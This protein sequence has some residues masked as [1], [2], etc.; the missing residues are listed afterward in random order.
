MLVAQSLVH[1]PKVIILDEPTAGVGWSCASRCGRL[2][3]VCTAKTNHHSTTHYLEEAERLCER[4][5][6]LVRANRRAGSH[7]DAVAAVGGVRLH[8]KLR[9]GIR[10]NAL[11]EAIAAFGAVVR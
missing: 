6:I 1:R 3:R 8:I 2:Y 7:L 11:P 9:N 5:A 10:L 4:I